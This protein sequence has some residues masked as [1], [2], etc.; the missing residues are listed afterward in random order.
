VVVAGQP[1][2]SDPGKHGFDGGMAG[3]RT[4]SGFKIQL[5]ITSGGRGV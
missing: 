2:F 3:H 1:G 5:G 4:S